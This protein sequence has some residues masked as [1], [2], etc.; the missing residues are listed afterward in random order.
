MREELLKTGSVQM[1]RIFNIYCD[2]SCYLENDNIPVI[3]WGSVICEKRFVQDLSKKIRVLKTEHG[4]GPDFEAKWTK[5]S[6]A[7]KG[8]YLALIDLFLEDTRLRFRGLLAPDKKLLNHEVFN[9]S[10]DEWYYKMY[11]LMLRQ[12]LAEPEC[13]HIYLDIKDTNGGPKIKKLHEY[14]ANGIKDF[15]RRHIERVQQIRSHE[16][17]LLQIADLLIGS[18]TYANR[19]L[20]ISIAK[21]AVLDRLREKLGEQVLIKT[22][23]L[24]STKFNVLLWQAQETVG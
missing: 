1:A 10:H 21:T 9:Q 17:E 20:N 14:L 3:A 7:K 18:L 8:F 23:D 5:V 22:S 13:Y 24:S 11:F 15:D 2:E 4:L 12:I 16:S 6:P 19:G